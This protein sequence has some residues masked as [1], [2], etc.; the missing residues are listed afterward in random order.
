[1]FLLRNLPEKRVLALFSPAKLNLFFAILGKRP[2]AY[3]EIFSLNQTISLGDTL[4]VE[5]ADTDLLTCN[6]PKIPVGPSNLIWRAAALF[7]E[8]TGFWQPL[9]I[10]LDK[11]IPVEAGLGG[12]SS[13]AA[14]VLFALNTLSCLEG[15]GWRLLRGPARPACKRPFPESPLR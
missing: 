8:K 3:H 6:D 12:G 10:H 7:R 14:T 5:L 1:M 2:D 9:R 4:R 15:Q 11:H 13:N